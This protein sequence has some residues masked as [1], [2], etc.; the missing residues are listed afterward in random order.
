MTNGSTTRIDSVL[1]DLRSRGA[2]L[3]EH[4]FGYPGD[5]VSASHHGFQPVSDS[6]VSFLERI[7]DDWSHFL[8]PDPAS[9]TYMT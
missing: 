8:G 7:R 4:D 1:R 6:F 5:A 3:E 2:E 9:W